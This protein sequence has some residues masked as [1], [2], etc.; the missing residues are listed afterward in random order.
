LQ[1]KEAAFVWDQF[2]LYG[3]WEIMRISLAI[4][5]AL[6]EKVKQTDSWLMVMQDFGVYL[7]SVQD[8]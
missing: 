5:Y 8:F 1:I 3:E 7:T 6:N 2:M 4:C